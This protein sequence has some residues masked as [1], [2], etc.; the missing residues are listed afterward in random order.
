MLRQWA[1]I[2]RNNNNF[3]IHYNFIN[4]VKKDKLTKLE[5]RQWKLRPCDRED[6]IDWMPHRIKNEGSITVYY[7]NVNSKSPSYA[8]VITLNITN[9]PVITEWTITD[10]NYYIYKRNNAV[11]ERTPTINRPKPEEVIG[12]A[13]FLSQTGGLIDDTKLP[14]VDGKTVF[15]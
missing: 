11:I 4:Y 12:I 7:V 14:S 2:T 13:G 3:S 6:T 5:M 10:G 9:I 15:L 1:N 8:N